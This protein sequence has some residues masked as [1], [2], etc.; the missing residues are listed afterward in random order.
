MRLT[1]RDDIALCLRSDPRLLCAVRGLVRPYLEKQ[2]VAAGRID[3]V[4]LA[5]D[6]ACTNAIR[7][8]YG[9]ATDREVW[10]ALRQLPDYIEVE[11]RDEGTPAPAER[12]QRRPLAEPDPD[13]VVPGGLGI[14][15]IYSAFDEVIFEPGPERGNRVRMRLRLNQAGETPCP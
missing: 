5:V 14:P 4:V 1:A 15:L 8:A 12:V 2:D 11:V 6:E 9:R 10:L 3:D 13:T 7:H